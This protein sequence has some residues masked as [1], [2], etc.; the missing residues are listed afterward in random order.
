MSWSAPFS[1]D[2]T[3]VDPDIWYSVLIYNVTDEEN[4]TAVPCTGCHN[5][6]QTNYTFRP[7]YSSP[8]HKYIYTFTIIPYNGAGEGE[9]SQSVNGYSIDM[10]S[11]PN[12]D[13]M[14][15]EIKRTSNNTRVKFQVSVSNI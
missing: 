12:I 5:L 15:I 4:P 10:Y 7:D 9:R 11:D 13:F 2:V 6:T 8:C 14:I 3:N 1:L